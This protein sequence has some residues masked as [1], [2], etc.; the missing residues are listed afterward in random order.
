MQEKCHKGTGEIICCT[1]NS[2]KRKMNSNVSV[3]HGLTQH[4][5]QQ[6]ANMLVTSMLDVS[7]IKTRCSK[8]MMIT[9]WRIIFVAMTQ[10]D[11]K[12]V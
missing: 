4:I 5:Y 9:G 3:T 11:E 10:E 6:K 2:P 7:I 12:H 1:T 8:V